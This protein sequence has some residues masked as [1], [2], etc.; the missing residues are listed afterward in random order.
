MKHLLNGRRADIIFIFASRYS[1]FGRKVLLAEIMEIGMNWKDIWKKRSFCA[2][3]IIECLLLLI[4]IAGLFLPG[5]TIE[6][7]S[8]Q[9]NISLNPGVYKVRVDYS[10]SEYGNWLEVRDT[11]REKGSVLFSTVTLYAGDLTEDCQ[12][13][14]LTPT[15]SVKV[16]VVYGGTG[17][18]IINRLEIISTNAGSRIF[19]FLVLTAGIVINGL[20]LLR[21][22]DERVGISRKKKIIWGML[23]F[24]FILV[25]VPCMI[26]YNLWG[27]DWGFH[28]LR[29]EGLISGLKDRQ[30]P[31]RIQGNWIQGYGYASSIFYSDLFMTI[32]MVFRLIGFSV[33]ASCRMFYLVIN[34]VTLIMAYQ[35]FRRS[36]KDDVAGLVGAVLYTGAAYR[37]HNLYMRSAMGE[38][39]AMVFL[40]LIFYGFYRIFTLDIHDKAYKRSFLPLTLGLTGVI[41][42]HVITC[43]MLALG[44]LVL[45]IVLVKKVFRKETFLE[46]VKT[47]AASV[48]LNLWYLLP[49]IDYYLNEKFNVSSVD[50]MVIKKTQSWGVYPAHLLFLFYGRGTRGGAGMEYTG[51]YS[52]GGALLVVF[53]VWLFLEF[54]GRLKGKNYRFKGLGRLMFSYTCLFFVLVSCYFPWDKL[55]NSSSLLE[56]LITSIQFPYRFLAMACL[57]GSVLAGVL[58]IWFRE[59]LTSPGFKGWVLLLLGASLF[60]L[61]YQTNQLLMNRG[62]AR[63]Y[64]KQSMGT[65]YVSNG[66]YLPPGADIGQMNYGRVAAGEGVTVTYFDKEQDTL[67]TDITVSNQGGESYVEL[68]VLYYRGYAAKDVETGKQLTVVAGDNSVVR[69]ILPGGYEGSIHVWFHSP[70]YWRL[71]EMIS[72]ASAV[73]L[74]LYWFGSRRLSEPGKA[75]AVPGSKPETAEAHVEGRR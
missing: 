22:Y 71:S 17:E 69:V 44:I 12:L 2:V 6:I 68:P 48:L 73:A 39:L 63:V 31:V 52:V 35:C 67:Q 8:G 62:F 43:E 23:V 3:I 13:W 45:C 34:G 16:E 37:I 47:V 50:T 59:N 61:S 58:V 53:F 26:D 19:I 32:P 25:S 64:A 10:A 49:F 56:T 66:E 42:S 14:V 41:Q 20:Y 4:G 9:E 40:P 70:W 7:E 24:T 55:Q 60:F 15:D 36:L 27:D 11:L 5:K 72:L 29:V 75:P 57:S 21:F 1:S 54:T 38:V 30:F 33:N 46:L 18:L 28:L 74:V 65:I 51:S